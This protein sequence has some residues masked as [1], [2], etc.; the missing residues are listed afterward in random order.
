MSDGIT[1]PATALTASGDDDSFLD[2]SGNLKLSFVDRAHMEPKAKAM[3][4]AG[5]NM[6]QLNRF[7]RHCRRIEFRLRRKETTWAEEKPEV[8]A[9]SAS[10]AD[11]FGKSPPKIP[12][13]FRD[14]I[15]DNVARTRTEDDFL[16]GFMKHFEAL[17]GFASIYVKKGQRG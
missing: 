14:F 2:A 11:A 8:A 7:F 15:Y 13:E 10:A 6:N 3:T 17:M 1:K 16:K 12:A 9:L 5:L 4:Q